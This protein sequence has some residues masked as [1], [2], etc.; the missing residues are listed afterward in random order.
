LLTVTETARREKVIAL[1]GNPNSGKT[2]I[3]NQ[4]TGGHQHVGNWSGVTVER[5]DGWL[6]SD[7][8]RLRITDLPGMY[9]LAADSPDE[10]IVRDFIVHGLGA[11]GRPDLV[12]QVIDGGSLERSLL[13]TMQLLEQDI[14]LVIALNMY[15]EVQRRGMLI[16]AEK[17]AQK[18][19]VPVVPTIGT[20][21]MG[22]AELV[23]AIRQTLRGDE[24]VPPGRSDPASK[25]SEA[26]HLDGQAPPASCRGHTALRNAGVSPSRYRIKFD[27]ATE[28][29]LQ[30]LQFLCADA[31]RPI[32]RGIAIGMLTGEPSAFRNIPDSTTET[33]QK[34]VRERQPDAGGSWTEAVVHARY[35][36]I[37]RLLAETVGSGGRDRVHSRTSHLD[38]VLIHRLWGIP[39]F[40]LILFLLFQITFRLG[41]YPADWIDRLFSFAADS[42]K[43]LLPR[44]VVADLMADGVIRGVGF[45]A[46]FLPNI[47]ILLTGIHLLEDSGY[48]ARA[49]FLMDRVMRLMG[50]HGRSFIPMMMGFGCNVPALMGTR[51]LDDRRDRLLTMLL[52]PLMS[53][54]ARLPVYVMVTAACFPRS[55][56]AVIFGLYLLGLV[57][58]VLLGRLFR[59]TILRGQAA[60]FVMELPP[61]RWPTLMT[62]WSVIRRTFILY[63][64]RIAVT[65]AIFAVVIWF[66]ANFPR[67]QQP[68]S[69]ATA[70]PTGAAVATYG[71][72]TYIHRLGDVINPVMKPLGFTLEMNIALIAG[73]IAKEVVVATMGVLYTGSGEVDSSTL[74]ERLRRDIPSP[75]VA[76]AFLV[77][78]L[79]YTPC[80]TTVV[81][82]QRETRHWV[83]TA[84]S[85]VYQTGVAWLAALATRHIATW[86]GLG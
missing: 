70:A 37:S 68:A 1:V 13:L 61:Y 66:L 8:V 47:V 23:A 49:A 82:L 75:A 30:H 74:I 15:D 39:L 43:A 56:G 27:A 31:G 65:V 51:I 59:R 57:T 53:C 29:A 20:R 83:W 34:L 7:G 12:V 55:G 60:P 26:H 58:A 9:S 85:I 62:T 33:I 4:L 16:N 18:L 80:L 84:F 76:L 36:A 41:G 54:S 52:I 63:L 48:M 77:F 50:L 17:L 42:V 46:V 45:I 2:S 40:L 44:G 64:R 19:G 69:S 73:F 22:V 38:A 67:V 5:R 72:T 32:P 21:G 81:T 35:A 79:L 86:A 78:V 24:G 25:L 14:P 6:E 71:E 3:F 28:T 11:D 10:V